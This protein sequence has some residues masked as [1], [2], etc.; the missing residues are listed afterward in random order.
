MIDIYRGGGGGQYL[1]GIK[2]E[3][4]GRTE[5]TGKC[6]GGRMTPE[7]SGVVWGGEGQGQGK[8]GGGV[9]GRF[10]GYDPPRNRVPEGGYFI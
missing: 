10:I 6:P 5:G 3:G 7:W 1:A 8:G 2:R 4:D 9:E